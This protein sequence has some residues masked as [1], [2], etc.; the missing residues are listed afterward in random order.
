MKKLVITHKVDIDG[1]GG[2]ILAN[3]AFGIKN[4]EYILAMPSNI[5]EIVLK[6]IEE[7]KYLDY[8]KIYV[9][10]ICP[11][12]SVLQKIDNDKKIKNKF[13]IFDHHEGKLQSLTKDYSFLIEKIR[14]EKGFT[15][16]TS[17]FYEYLISNNLICKKESIEKL[18]ELTR[19]YDTWEW[20]DIYN[21]EEANMLTILMEALGY[22]LYISCMTKK[23]L[24]EDKFFFTDFEKQ[25]I[26]NKKR[27]IQNYVEEA[28]ENIYVIKIDGYKAAIC[29]AEKY[30]NDIKDYIIENKIFDVDILIIIKLK[31]KSISYRSIK[32]NVDVNKFA[33]KYGGGGHFSAAGSQIEDFLIKRIT[34]V[35]FN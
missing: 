2:A 7:K 4:V 29:Y 21:D 28:V 26:V 34:R 1:H 13:L 33:K 10:D 31:E 19:R 17:L 30:R 35:I 15:C 23:L 16:G 8:D 22:D 14:D 27:E 25:L 9:T 24:E 20:K 5:D 6:I 32:E 12:D 18:V 3:I 11:T